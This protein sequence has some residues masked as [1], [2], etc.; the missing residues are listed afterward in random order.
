MSELER[1]YAA[2]LRLY[3]EWYRRSRG[4]EML[5]VLMDSAPPD[6]RRPEWRETRGLILG[7]LRVRA[8]AHG[9]R[10]AGQSWRVSL[11]IAALMLLIQAVGDVLWQMARNPV[12]VSL[13]VVA[14]CVLAMVAVARGAYLAATVV[15][16]GAFVLDAVARQTLYAW[17]S[18]WPLP[19]AVVL[20]IPLIGRGTIVVPRALHVL[21]LVPVVSAAL[22]GYGTITQDPS[23]QTGSRAVWQSLAVAAILW[24]VIDERVTMSFGLAFLYVVVSRAMADQVA[25]D[26]WSLGYWTLID[27]GTLAILP[28]LDIAVGATVAVRRTRI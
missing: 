17:S 15:T 11:R 23:F 22:M 2:L 4:A 7:A 14:A 28:V 6:R 8:G 18:S 20:L 21:L 10:T 1:R 3:P 24:S 19:L 27:M 26:D 9:H 25:L 5:A 16:A 12:A 13:A